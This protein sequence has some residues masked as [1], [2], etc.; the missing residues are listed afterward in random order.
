VKRWQRWASTTAA[1][2]VA[3]LLLA[4]IPLLAPNAFAQSEPLGTHEFV[5]G[6]KEAPPF[7]IKSDTGEWSGVSIELWRKLADQWCFRRIGELVAR[8]SRFTRCRIAP[9]QPVSLLYGVERLP[10]RNTQ[11]RFRYVLHYRGDP[12][13]SSPF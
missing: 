2:T 9:I 11:L 1:M 3:A 8:A 4:S 10:E 12:D 13:C 6:T 5:V 7:A